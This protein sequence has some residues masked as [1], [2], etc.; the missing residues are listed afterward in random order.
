MNLELTNQEANAIKALIHSKIDQIGEY[1]L[2]DTN[3]TNVLTK[4]I[5]SQSK[6]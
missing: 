1:E 5:E 6:R 2:L 4:I 3:I